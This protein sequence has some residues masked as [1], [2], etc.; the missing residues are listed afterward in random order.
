MKP[1]ILVIMSDQHA[2]SVIG[3]LGHPTVKT[4]HLDQLASRGVAFTQAY[5][6][7]PMCTPS[8][9]SFMTGLL[10]P[11]HNVWELGSP[12]S[13][14]IPTWAHAL[15][16][17][18]Y[19]TSISGR[20]HFIG[21]DQLHG[22]Q[23]RVYPDAHVGVRPMAYDPWLKPIEDEHVMI[24]SV[25][26]GGPTP[27]PT[28]NEAYDRGVHEAALEELTFL[29]NQS[30]SD[31]KP[32]A[33]HV[34]FIQ[35]HAPFNVSK[36][37]WDLYDGVDIPLPPAPPKGNWEAHIP[38]HMRGS[39]RWL[40]L[41]TDGASDEQVKNARRAYYAMTTQIDAM[42]GQLID[43]LRANGD[44]EN[45]LILYTSDHGDNHGNH[46]MWSKLNFFQQSV[47]TPFILAGAGLTPSPGICH[48]PISLVDF[49]PT[50]LDLTGQS[51]IWPTPLAGCS[52]L[53]LLQNPSETWPRRPVIS[54]YACGG[55]RVP[56]RMV[57]LGQYKACFAPPH[58]PV[59]FD[60]KN[61]P[62]EWTDLGSDPAHQSTLAH[63]EAAARQDGWDPAS[64]LIHIRQ[65]K[66]TLDYL[67]GVEGGEKA[68]RQAK[69]R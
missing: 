59:L 44:L 58:P 40:G 53:P 5:C 32:W 61:D 54:D 2:P 39:R 23:R 14:G 26:R 66:R 24:S 50:L 11:Q 64:L 16:S 69:T 38:E 22:F 15:R 67:K 43:R 8:R 10:A 13:S 51:S 33:L 37:W 48:A 7:Y 56:I 4:P 45:T 30:K 29:S 49:L 55:T 60:L 36:P 46:G 57:R 34:G 9:A 68:A 20:M 1:N 63:L 41:S 62:N 3:A 42:V 21:D 35:P 18:G 17:A 31:G 28:K 19:T 27:E 12:L 25:Q 47:G 52:L 6:P 65:E